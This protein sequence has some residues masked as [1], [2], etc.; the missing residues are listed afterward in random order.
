MYLRR[1][2]VATRCIPI[3]S[4]MIEEGVNGYTVD[5]ENAEQLANRM[6]MARHLTDLEMIYEP[7]KPEDFIRL[8]K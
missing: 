5:V 1:P 4:R 3:I 8:F 2:V 7:G 6:L